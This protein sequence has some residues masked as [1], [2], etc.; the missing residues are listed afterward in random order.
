MLRRT[1]WVGV[2][3]GAAVTILL[4][5]LLRFPT[6]RA[7]VPGLYELAGLEQPDGIIGA[8]LDQWGL[9]GVFHM[10][11]L[12]SSLLVPHLFGGLVAGRMVPFS[13][14]LYGATTAVLSALF[15][16]AAFFTWLGTSLL[17]AGNLGLVF[18]WALSFA[19]YFPLT[20]LVA[21]LGGKLGGR[22]RIGFS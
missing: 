10:L 15:G 5:R 12:L 4:V 14:G 19:V 16:I 3:V 2:V 6:D 18:F 8:P 7:I 11:I 17:D 20:L 22:F 9:V 1:R 21:Y 13:P